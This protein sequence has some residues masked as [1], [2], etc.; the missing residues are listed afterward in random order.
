MTRGYKILVP[1]REMQYHVVDS[2]YQY[3]QEMTFDRVWVTSNINFAYPFYTESAAQEM[4]WELT[5]LTDRW[6]GVVDEGDA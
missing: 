2:K 3:F 5:A 6:F 4:A 1:A